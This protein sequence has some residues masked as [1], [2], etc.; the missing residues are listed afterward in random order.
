[1]GSLSHIDWGPIT[2][3]QFYSIKKRQHSYPLPLLLFMALC[4]V[5]LF[6]MTSD[7]A[8]AQNS[9]RSLVL[10]DQYNEHYLSPY[11]TRYTQT[12]N[13]GNVK[14]IVSNPSLQNEMLSSSGS[15]V[16]LDLS[17]DVTW[18][19]FDVTNRSDQNFW[20]VK[21]GSSYDGRFGLLDSVTAYTFDRETSIL[22]EYALSEDK[23]VELFLPIN[24]K[25]QV[26]LKLDKTQSLPIT[27]PLRL[28]NTAKN[29]E[30]VLDNSFL[31][32]TILLI[33]MAFFFMA[34][35]VIKYNYSYLYFSFYYVCL[36]LLLFTQNNFI[37]FE[38]MFVGG[39]LQAY[40]IFLIA[41]TSLVIANFFW[42]PG[43]H[44]FWSKPVFFVPS[45]LGLA[46]IITGN[47]VH[48]TTNLSNFFL[49]IGPS[50]LIILIIPLI[51]I[52]QGQTKNNNTTPFMLG[53]FILLF[54]ICISILALSGILQP[55]STAINAYWFTLIP[56]AIFFAVATRMDIHTQFENENLTLSKTLEINES[57]SISKLR[58][59]KENTEQERLLK[60]IDQER[61]VLGE[62]RKSEARQTEE[63]RKAKE[64]ADEANK[65]KSAFLAVVSHEIRTPMTGI[66]GM[67]RM[68]LNSNLTKEQK[69]YAQTIQDSSDAMLALLNDILDF[70]KIEQGKMTFENISF[71]LHRLIQGV[72]TLMR[73][74]AV[75]K[76]IELHTKIGKDLPN[77]VMGDP[78]RLR[79]VLLNLTGNAVK[80]TEEGGV[81]ITAELMKADPGSNS[82]E[83]YF[84]VTDN[85]IGISEKAK[86]DLFSPFSQADKTI[87]RKFG[88]TGLGLAI[89]K[90]L[91]TGM[92]SEINISSAEGEGSTFFFTLS[93]EGGQKETAVATANTESKKTKIAAKKILLID[94]NQINRKVVKGLLS[95]L[96]Y[97]IQGEASA[98]EGLKQLEKNKFDIVLMD[99]ELPDMNG[100]EATKKIRS[101]SNKDVKDIPVI[102]LTGNTKDEHIDHYYD[103][104]ISSFISK[105]IDP[106]TL[107]KK[108]ES[109]ANGIFDKDNR[110]PR[111][112]QIVP[113]VIENDIPDTPVNLQLDDNDA[114]VATANA[115]KIPAATPPDIKPIEEKDL[116]KKPPKISAPSPSINIKKTAPAQD[117]QTEKP[118]T[119]EPE[120]TAETAPSKPAAPKA[121]T[122]KPEGA[123]GLAAAVKANPAIRNESEA[124][125]VNTGDR[126]ET[127]DFE[128]L[129]SL[130][131]HLSQDKIEE[132]IDDVLQKTDE[133]VSDLTSALSS[134]DQI[135]ISAK[136]HDLKGMAGNFGLKEISD[137][138]KDIELKSKSQPT[139]ITTTLV[140]SLPD[141]KKRA[142]A[143]LSEWYASNDFRI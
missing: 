92:G 75:Q 4:F 142:L 30:K 141:A 8:T 109:A 119:Q 42:Y 3:M 41:V 79:Q 45:A 86:E 82:Y 125:P 77:F 46:S 9:Y 100:D 1:M 114:S 2:I 126:E 21:F 18:L 52:M 138:A 131:K 37:A 104:G 101:S 48:D 14:D 87:S 81:T 61:K 25:S 99:I 130:K 84:S 44:K 50:I 68:L 17:E 102:A 74:H 58:Q 22:K 5:G 140:N 127:L 35:S 95:E 13:I 103:C 16:L 134:G 28:V 73:G 120:T 78:T 121:V 38:W 71:D 11:M 60:V 91:V 6:S 33:G 34:V 63:M 113:N 111:R 55:V 124:T 143:A 133:I 29:H 62:L 94:D 90:G 20:A 129:S 43:E 27:T 64:I 137:L 132:M 139:I 76:G 36:T 128:V 67:V 19:T 116:N 112:K 96:P 23:H 115:E 136:C 51:S 93:M 107:M 85:G 98:E 105:P 122:A 32:F 26:I 57:S 31:V 12:D 83:I 56:Q 54:G 89:S 24:E 53:W 7:T 72:A 97:D 39:E 118:L 80:F 110:A 10:S 15:I 66:M 65:G 106:S 49:T 88:G 69:E 47:F 117:S 123:G 135:T 59:S 70:E 40:L 108:I